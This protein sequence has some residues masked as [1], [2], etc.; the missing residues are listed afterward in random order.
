[1]GDKGNLWD[2]S[3]RQPAQRGGSTQG[4]ADCR[5]CSGKGKNYFFFPYYSLVFIYFI[6]C[7]VSLR[8]FICGN[9]KNIVKDLRFFSDLPNPP[10][11]TTH[12]RS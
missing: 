12:P 3:V 6:C 1:M 2:K 11:R 5:R 10:S 7:S 4:E 8:L 9:A